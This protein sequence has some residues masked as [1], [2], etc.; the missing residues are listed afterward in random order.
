[1]STQD[2]PGTPQIVAQRGIQPRHGELMQRCRQQLM[3]CLAEHLSG[4]FAQ[5]DDTLFEHAEKAENNQLQG[6]FF[7]SM[8]AIRKQRPHIERHYHQYIAQQF[9][10][11]LDQRDPA[12]LAPAQELDAEQLSLIQN[13][14]YEE[15][16]Q[17]TNMVSRVKARCAQSLF[18]LEQRLALQPGCRLK[19][20]KQTLCRL[21]MDV[22]AKVRL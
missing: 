18:T 10:A 20:N 12:H 2:Q 3:N 22:T 19:A 5:V 7:D 1:M 4:V 21:Y 15:S 14:E 6:L 9:S 11:F 16:L 17:V 8:R 13:D